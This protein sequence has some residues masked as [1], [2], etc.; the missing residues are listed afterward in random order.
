MSRFILEYDVELEDVTKNLIYDMCTASMWCDDSVQYCLVDVLE[1]LT[2]TPNI[3][4]ED[5]NYLIKLRNEDDVDYI[6]ITN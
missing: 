6:E 5:L 3:D 1:I 4:C 2:K